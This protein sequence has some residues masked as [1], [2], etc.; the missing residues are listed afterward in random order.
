MIFVCQ[1]LY[2]LGIVITVSKT[3]IYVPGLIQ[4][5]TKIDVLLVVSCK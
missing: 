5:V 3:G 2:K 1:I 4:I